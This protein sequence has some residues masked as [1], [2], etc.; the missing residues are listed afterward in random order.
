M[1]NNSYHIKHDFGHGKEAL[2]SVPAV[3]I[4]LAFAVHSA[5]ELAATKS[6]EARD[7]LG[8]RIRPFERLHMFA[9]W[10]ALMAAFITGMPLPQT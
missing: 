10:E 5:C 9:S 6:T 7:K 3:P 4:L 1:K 8:P 2:A